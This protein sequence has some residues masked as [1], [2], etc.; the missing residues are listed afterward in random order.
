MPSAASGAI[1]FAQLD[2][3]AQAP[4]TSTTLTLFEDITC[5][6]HRALPPHA[7]LLTPPAGRGSEKLI[8][9]VWHHGA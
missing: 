6:L 2:P 4:W 3:S 1:T 5:S 8:S 9:M 7:L